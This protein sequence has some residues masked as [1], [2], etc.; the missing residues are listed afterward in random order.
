LGRCMK[1]YHSQRMGH[2]PM[3]MPPQHHSAMELL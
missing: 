3:G 2:R 1:S